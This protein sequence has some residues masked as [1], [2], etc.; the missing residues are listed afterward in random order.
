MWNILPRARVAPGEEA[1]AMASAGDI[2]LGNPQEEQAHL[3]P[4]VI[5]VFPLPRTVLLPGELLPLHVFEPRYRALAHDALAADR[6][7]RIVAIKPGHE[8]EAP[9]SPPLVDVGCLGFIAQH[10]EFP[11]GRFLLWLVGLEPFHVDREVIATA[12]YRTVKVTYLPT[13]EPTADQPS[14]SRLRREL[15]RLLPAL[16]GSERTAREMMREQLEDV[17][18]SQLV[19]LACQAL[20]LDPERKQQVLE[21]PSVVGRYIAV[22]E[23]LYARLD[24]QTLVN[25]DSDQVN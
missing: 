24:Q 8:E 12:P 22:F 5:P 20:E 21:T 6:V 19:A 10:T 11:D 7:F 16:L 23:D 4:D 25:E 1:H 13:A 3:V 2:Q 18:D 15:K 9:G 14:L 17:T